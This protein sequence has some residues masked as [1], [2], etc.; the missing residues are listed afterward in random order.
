MMQAENPTST[1]LSSGVFLTRK[2][3]R[4]VAEQA[5]ARSLN[6]ILGYPEDYSPDDLRRDAEGMVEELLRL[7]DAMDG[8]PDLEPNGDELDQSFTNSSCRTSSVFGG[9]YED[10][11]EEDP[12]EP[13]LASPESVQTSEAPPNAGRWPPEGIH[14]T[15][16]GRQT[17]WA[18][19]NSA[20]LEGDAQEDDEDGHDREDDRSDTEPSL[21]WTDAEAGTGRY[22]GRFIEDG[23]KEQLRKPRRRKPVGLDNVAPFAPGVVLV[24]GKT[25]Y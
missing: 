23:E 13:S 14:R 4:V 6:N 3:E 19:G 9:D 16:E 10:A 1:N 12:G 17:N 21:G 5:A 20:D 18:R 25:A 8:D 24:S 2:G 15:G 7:L 11:E 22:A